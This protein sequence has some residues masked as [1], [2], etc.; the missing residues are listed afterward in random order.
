ME[1]ILNDQESGRLDK[2]IAETEK[3]SGAQIVTAVIRRSDSYTELPWK[4]F[5]FGASCAAFLLF[6]DHLLRPG[7][8]R[9]SAALMIITTILA[10]GITSAL[11]AL[12][13]PKFA[14]LFLSAHR[15]EAEVRQYAESLFLSRELFATSR[16]TG[17]LLLVS[18]FERRVILLPDTGLN[19]RLSGEAMQKIIGQMTPILASGQVALALETGLLKLQEILT[20]TAA[21]E[22]G[23]NEL[24]NE[25]IEEK[26]Q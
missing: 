17:L 25:L 23:T 26:G 8:E 21:G 9:Q 11:L 14:R 20:A 24:P 1:K 12:Y 2:L 15:C 13:M 3:R 7:W 19:R 18:L 16:R 4:A 10:A 22:P 6:I 5:A